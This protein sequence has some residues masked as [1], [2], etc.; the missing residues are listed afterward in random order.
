MHGHHAYTIRRGVA[1]PSKLNHLAGVF[2]LASLLS[3]SNT[4]GNPD[5]SASGAVPSGQPPREIS[6][7]ME[8]QPTALDAMEAK[9][10]WP[11]AG[12]GCVKARSGNRCLIGCGADIDCPAQ[13]ICL[14][15]ND[16]CSLGVENIRDEL[17]AAVE[18]SCYPLDAPLAQILEE[19]RRR[20]NCTKHPR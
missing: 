13:S 17:P 7:R 5:A 8:R 20:K 2:A 10:A 11:C 6:S 3:C 19:C 18:G 15:E 14:C 16:K 9:C 12:P 4:G 1:V